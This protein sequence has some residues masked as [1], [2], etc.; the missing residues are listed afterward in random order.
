MEAFHAQL[1]AFAESVPLPTFISTSLQTTFTQ[2]TRIQPASQSVPKR[3]RIVPTSVIE[4]LNKLAIRADLCNPVAKGSFGEVFFGSL[5]ETGEPVVLKRSLPHPT[6]RTLFQTER[7]INRKIDTPSISSSHWPKY[8]GDYFR[9][10]QSF[11]VWRREGEGNT[12]ASYL[13]ARPIAQL[14]QV[15]GVSATP[16]RLNVALFRRVVAELLHALNCLHERGVVH[17][18]IKPSNILIAPN[19]THPLK[20]IDFGSSCD[21]K[22]LFWSRGV[23]T[24]DPLYAAPEQ[25]LSLVAPEKFDIFSVALI[26]VSVLMPSFASASRLREFKMRLGECDFDLRRYRSEMRS[27]GGDAGEL[28]ALFDTSDAEAVEVFELLNAMLKKS[29]I[30]RKSV[31]GALLDLGLL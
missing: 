29:P 23:D 20:L 12:L 5:E 11:L 8:L 21:V 26:G 14:C 19:E 15:L 6:A 4:P 16:A 31:K 3:R 10:S 25:R 22:K 27:I 7:A 1:L 30:A 18:D 24:L 17:R 13:D 28:G 9:N 2:T